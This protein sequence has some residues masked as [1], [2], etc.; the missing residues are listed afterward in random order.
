MNFSSLVYCNYM[1]QTNY[2][3]HLKLLEK[4][5]YV[6][7]DIIMNIAVGKQPKLNEPCFLS[8]NSSK[9]T[10]TKLLPNYRKYKI[11]ISNITNNINII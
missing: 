3:H 8:P 1:T 9:K 2:N 6:P 4:I 11:E 7:L 10:S 5:N